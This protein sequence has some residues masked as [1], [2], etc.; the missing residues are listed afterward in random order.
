MDLLR[1]LG[2]VSD[3]INLLCAR[4][5]TIV[6]RIAG[7][8]FDAEQLRQRLQAIW[9]GPLAPPPDLSQ[10]DAEIV[11]LSDTP[12]Q[13][14]VRVPLWSEGRPTAVVVSTRV[15][16]QPDGSVAVELTDITHEPN[17]RIATDAVAH[18]EIEAVQAFVDQRRT[19]S[20]RAAAERSARLATQPPP[21]ISPSIGRAVMDV[22]AAILGGRLD[23]LNRLAGALAPQMPVD[24]LR[25]E[26][27]RRGGGW[28][29]PPRSAL[30]DIEVDPYDESM[31]EVEVE[32]PMWRD[33]VQ[34]A[35]RL[36]LYLRRR[37]NGEYD[38]VVRNLRMP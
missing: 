26:L 32:F 25:D 30:Y 15:W 3:V 24:V 23:E 1:L 22:L 20:K 8:Q 33:N 16:E 13:W 29:M 27:E 38:V 2:A 4:Q 19:E 21:E 6:A 31:G 7:G 36:Y 11:R 34:T 5:Y 12:P 14:Q 37:E 35:V 18:S 9:T 10:S 28:T 17:Y